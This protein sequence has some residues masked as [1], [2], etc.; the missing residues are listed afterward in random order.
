ML[1][2][3]LLTSGHRGLPYRYSVLVTLNLSSDDEYMYFGFEGEETGVGFIEPFQ[4]A[5]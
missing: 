5:Y 3:I 1:Q 4:A 2:S